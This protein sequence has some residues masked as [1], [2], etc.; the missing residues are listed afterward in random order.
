[1]KPIPKFVALD[2]E[3]ADSSN[4]GTICSIG[5]AV[6]ENGQVIQEYNK[7]V[8]PP[9]NKY[10]KHQITKMNFSPEETENA[11]TFKD[12]YPE[13]HELLHNNIV[14]AHNAFSTEKTSI[15][16]AREL[17]G[18][19]D[20][21]NIDWICTKKICCDCGLEIAARVCKIDL[22]HHDALSDA[23]ACGHLY[24]KSLK[25]ELPIDEIIEHHQLYLEEKKVIRET[26]NFYP[27]SLKGDI[28][29]PDFENVEDKTNPFYMKKVVITGF[30]DKNK[31]AE[32]LKRLG[33]DIDTGVGKYT[34]FLICGKTPGITKKR[35]MQQRIDLGHDCY[36]IDENQY[37]ELIKDYI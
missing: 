1:M 31:I 10:H 28:L 23:I 34:D 25:G 9:D 19:E 24:L 12:I 17:Y 20:E 32:E 5:I 36:I 27:E 16:K 35:Q 8:R 37:N 21:L 29:K 2:V 13:I 26:Q 33:A 3:F 11:P 6:F 15:R 4:Q 30:K 22:K 14:V 7:K 18:I